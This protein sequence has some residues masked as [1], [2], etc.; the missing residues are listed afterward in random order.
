MSIYF[1]HA[2]PPRWDSRPFKSIAVQGSFLRLSMLSP[3]QITVMMPLVELPFSKNA[4]HT[5]GPSPRRQH[6]PPSRVL[7][8]K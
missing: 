1:V 6:A 8:Y 5:L 7:A 3:V 4:R 2:K